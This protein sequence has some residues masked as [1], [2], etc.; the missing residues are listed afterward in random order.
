MAGR[1]R[2]VAVGVVVLC[3]GAPDA[4]SSFPGD[5]GL[6]AYARETGESDDPFSY[7][8]TISPD[9]SGAE[10]I[11]PEGLGHVAGLAWSADGKWVAFSS[12]PQDGHGPEIFKMRRD[13]SRL[14]LLTTGP[15]Q[16]MWP[17]WSPSGR[18]LTFTSQYRTHQGRVWTMR[19]DGTNKRLINDIP[20]N[21]VFP[22]WSPTG[23]W[24]VYECAEHATIRLVSPDGERARLLTRSDEWLDRMPSWSPS[25][26][27]IIFLGERDGRGAIRTM[28]LDGRGRRRIVSPGGYPAFS[29]DGNFIVFSRMV[30]GYQ[31]LFKVRRDGS[32]LVQLTTTHGINE[33]TPDWQP[34]P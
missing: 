32:G 16:G 27:R 14:T 22:K 5:N 34:R 12:I 28:R 9:G 4:R 7:L 24:I 1:I 2:V 21:A 29:P 3:L 10:N 13:G 17:A 11:T 25:G 8:Y 23:T 18:R 31:D 15:M 33:T 20:C 6:V 19:A 30:D 26:R